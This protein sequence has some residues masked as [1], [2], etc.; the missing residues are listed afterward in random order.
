MAKPVCMVGSQPYTLRPP[1]PWTSATS[2]SGFGKWAGPYGP[3]PDA[4]AHW[5]EDQ[6]E[7]LYRGRA[8][9]LLTG[10]KALRLT[11]SARAQRDAAKREALRELIGYLQKR[12]SM[13]AYRDLIE[14]DLVIASGIVEGAAR[15]VVGERL[16]CSGMRWIPERAE[17]LLHL[18]C[19]E[20]NGE[21]ERFFAW[22]YQR[23]LE[24]MRSGHR[25][26]LRTN[27]VDA[28]PIEASMEE[29]E[30][31]CPQQDNMPVAA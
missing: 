23:W 19:I 16:D 13:M 3:S 11:L 24:R 7:L 26:V 12:L 10:L 25:V 29:T 22:S 18:R 27:Q 5:V 8:A 14:A 17:T 9:Q 28:L 6:R 4:V 21:W 20:L 15:Y 31:Q 30:T 2:K 1:L